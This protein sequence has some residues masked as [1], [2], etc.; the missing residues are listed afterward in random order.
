MRNQ[1]QGGTR[2]AVEFKQ[3]VGNRLARAC[4][5]AA[6]WF[7]GQQDLRPRDEGPRQRHALLLAARKRRWIMAA[8]LP[9]PYPRKQFLR[10]IDLR[11]RIGRTSTELKRQQHIFQSRQVRQQLEGLEDESEALRAHARAP[12]LIQGKDVLAKEMHGAAAGNVQ[13][14]EQAQQRRFARS[15]RAQDC[16]RLAAVDG[17]GDIFEHR[18]RRAI[19]IEHD[20]AQRTRLYGWGQI[21]GFGRHQEFGPRV[22]VPATARRAALRALCCILLSAIGV[23]SLAPV[24]AAEEP[25]ARKILVLGDSLSAEYGLPRGTGWVALLDRRIATQAPQY[26]VVN[27][28]ISG[29]T[30][31]GGRSRIDALLRQHHPR[32]TIIELGANDGLRGLATD[33]M[34]QN[35]QAII[36]ACKAAGSRVL[37]VG[38]RVPPNYGAAYGDRFFA[39][40]GALARS[41]H[42]ALVPFLLDG[43][44]EHLELFQSDRMHPLAQA[45]DRML[46]NVWPQLLQLLRAQR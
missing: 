26:S 2:L 3:Q 18:Q 28:S 1:H 4:I 14:G 31:R 35:L 10:Q 37:L 7:I 36:D 15:G 45:Q 20:L 16:H 34:Q 33:A 32:I 11:P 9:Q 30:S 38:I 27:A 13:S 40:Y 21:L 42:L 25:R 44:A 43:F 29:D 24:M 23:Q 22:V 12:V 17:Q 5:Q 46:D 39:V 41:N 19:G 8:A 6:G